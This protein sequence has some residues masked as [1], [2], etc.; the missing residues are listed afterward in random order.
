[1]IADLVL[2]LLATLLLMISWVVGGIAGL[3]SLVPIFDNFATGLAF[4]VDYIWYWQGVIDVPATFWFFD[5]LLVFF[6]C[7]F[8]I[9]VSMWLYSMVRYGDHS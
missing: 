7:I 9:N 4:Y 8:F 1:M 2:I 3:F 5:R 6:A